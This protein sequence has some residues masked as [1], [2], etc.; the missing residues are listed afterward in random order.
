MRTPSLLTVLVPNILPIPNP[1]SISNALFCSLPLTHSRHLQSPI[2]CNF[3]LS[4]RCHNEFRPSL[5][6]FEYSKYYN[7]YY[8]SLHTISQAHHSQ[9]IPKLNHTPTHNLP[10]TT[11]PITTISFLINSIYNQDLVSQFYPKI[12][13]STHS[14]SAPDST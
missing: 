10:S 1:H 11:R 8:S 4:V 12:H 13:K 3:I 2:L 5:Y 14:A 9:L 6:Y 7:N